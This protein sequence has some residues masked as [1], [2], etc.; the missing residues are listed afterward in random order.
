[1]MSFLPKLNL[2]LILD[3]VT[4]QFGTKKFY[5][6]NKEGEPK[7]YNKQKQEEKEKLIIYLQRT[8][9]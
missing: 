3:K 8:D 2:A 6:M 5:Q 4:L 1:M 7:V 9:V